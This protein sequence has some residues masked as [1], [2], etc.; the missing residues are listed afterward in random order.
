[1][2]CRGGLSVTKD[3]S[4]KRVVRRHG[5]ETGQRYTEAL[6]DLEGLSARE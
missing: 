2:V 1:M 4:F 6:T 5:Q 3:A